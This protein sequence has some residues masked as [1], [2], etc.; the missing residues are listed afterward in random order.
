MEYAEKPLIR[1]AGHLWRGSEG[2]SGAEQ[3]ERKN[4]GLEQARFDKCF[5]EY[6]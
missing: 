4:N 2:A 6:L 1:E 3:H 5:L